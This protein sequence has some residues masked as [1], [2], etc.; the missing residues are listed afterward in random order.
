MIYCPKKL[1]EYFLDKENAS[2]VSQFIL[3][4][5]KI[6]SQLIS[7]NLKLKVFGTH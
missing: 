1:Y 3:E 6:K 7:K 5:E 4:A 2:K